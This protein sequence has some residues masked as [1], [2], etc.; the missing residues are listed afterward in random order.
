MKQLGLP[1]ENS[2]DGICSAL[3]NY[4]NNLALAV[5]VPGKASITAMCFDIG[6]LRIPTKIPAVERGPRTPPVCSPR[7]AQRAG[8]RIGLRAARELAVEFGDQHPLRRE[9]E[10]CTCSGDR[11]PPFV[12]GEL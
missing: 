11:R 10:R 3:P 8:A 2:R 1:N 9:E 6:G 4:H 7:V 12:V 5:L